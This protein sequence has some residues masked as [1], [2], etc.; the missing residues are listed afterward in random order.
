MSTKG[1]FDSLAQVALICTGSTYMAITIPFILL[2]VY[3]IQRV[4]LKTS[5]QLRFMD[6]EAKAPIFTHFLEFGEGVA[7][8]R[9]FGWEEQV[10]AANARLIDASQS[11]YYLMYCIQRWLQLVL[12]LLVAAVA[13]ILVALAVSLRA[14]STAGLLGVALDNVLSFNQFLTR[15]IREWTNLET[16]LSAISR[17]ENFSSSTPSDPEPPPIDCQTVS[18]SWPH[19]GAISFSNVSA[20]YSS[21]NSDALPILEDISFT[22][23]PGEKL[24]LC[25][26]TGSGK[27]SLL[28]TI[29]RLLPTGKGSI[30]IDGVDIAT[31][32][33]SVLRSR[34]TTIPQDAF[35]IPG[36]LR[37]NLDI[38]CSLSDIE[39]I[40]ALQKVQLW[41]VLEERGGLQIEVKV[42]SL[43]QGQMQLL[44]LARATLKKGKV[45]L[46]DEATSDLDGETDQLVQRV[47][48]EEFRGCTVI[49]IA[50]RVSAFSSSVSSFLIRS[51]IRDN[52]S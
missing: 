33:S 49:A 30:V 32:P 48:R 26:R 42:G 25:G 40:S 52:T 20:S 41:K 12:D 50:H 31:I 1:L 6:L 47:L 23:K 51:A 35:L 16:S 36:T 27:S 44:S 39:L 15:L 10:K 14:T 2:A 19:P 38:T 45:L 34:L 21:S 43:S 7:T 17:I 37:K 29:L 8:I 5:R 28:L 11:P 3:C 18:D 24:G 9:A 13:V 46:L 4:Y 22:L